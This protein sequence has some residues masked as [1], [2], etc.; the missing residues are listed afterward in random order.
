MSTRM[1]W[2]FKT[3]AVGDTVVFRAD[4]VSLT[5]ARSAMY[6]YTQKSGVRFESQLK[7]SPDGVGLLRV[8]CV[9]ADG[10]AGQ[11]RVD[12]RAL[13]RVVY[14]YES[15]EVGEYVEYEDE[16]EAKRAL[17]GVP[18]RQRELGRTFSTHR[19]EGLTKNTPFPFPTYIL[20]I[21]RVA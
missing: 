8:T 20:R 1:S 9:A 7:E 2:P 13:R 16:V 6:A 11:A 18:N 14:G 10:P 5:R 3:M 12:R 4:E 17:S 19:Y 21:T 15:L